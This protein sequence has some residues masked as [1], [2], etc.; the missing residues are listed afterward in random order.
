MSLDAKSLRTDYYRDAS[1]YWRGYGRVVHI[2]TGLVEEFDIAW[3]NKFGI[4][5]AVDALEARVDQSNA[6]SRSAL[7]GLA[8]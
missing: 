2:P 3:N 4:K 7:S 1:V 8:L 6:N 5:A